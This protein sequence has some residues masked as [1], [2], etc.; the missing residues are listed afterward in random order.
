MGVN[1]TRGLRGCGGTIE[2]I[3][4]GKAQALVVG[5]VGR[6]PVDMWTLRNSTGGRMSW[7]S[8]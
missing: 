3:V 2:E 7:W 6:I 4:E 1:E 8:R 5:G